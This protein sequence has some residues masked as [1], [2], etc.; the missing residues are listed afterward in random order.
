[1]INYT[2]ERIPK[3]ISRINKSVS[4]HDIDNSNSVVYDFN[5]FGYRANH[6]YT[7][8]LDQDKIVCIG[9]SIT[10]G[11]G[12]YVEETWPY[13]LS[14]ELK[15]P[16][17]QLSI[18]GASHG[19]VMWQIKNVIENIQNKDI[20][21][22][23]PPFGRV[24]QITDSWFINKNSWEYESENENHLQSNSEN[25]YHLNDFLIKSVV[26]NYNIN[27]VNGGMSGDF[28]KKWNRAR[29]GQH[30]DVEFQEY[31]VNEFLK[32]I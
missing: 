11:V 25:L 30:F 6:N 22:F 1:M 9:C 8:L 28:D 10:E 24:F 4:N 23:N 14:Q 2:L 17:I 3:I 21:V 12:L 32:N 16:Y 29:D 20:Y 27:F 7:P 31:V 5:D 18:A 13:M 19:Y 26:E 15:K